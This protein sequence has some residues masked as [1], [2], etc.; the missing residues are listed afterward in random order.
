MHRLQHFGVQILVERYRHTLAAFG[1]I[2]DALVAAIAVL[3]QQ[4]DLEADLHPFR[5]ICRAFTMRAGSSGTS[6]PAASG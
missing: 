3:A 1:E 6:A 4:Q 5:Q 2:E